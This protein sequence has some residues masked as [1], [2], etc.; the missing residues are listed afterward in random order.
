MVIFFIF[1]IFYGRLIERFR[2]FPGTVHQGRHR[3]G[4][5]LLLELL[6]ARQEDHGGEREKG[7][8]R[9]NETTLRSPF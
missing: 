5:D 1:F 8:R 9:F 2:L 3:I 7:T 4:R 6:R